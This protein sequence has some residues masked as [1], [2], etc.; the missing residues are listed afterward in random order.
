MLVHEPDG[1]TTYSLSLKISINLFAKVRASSANPLLN[2]GCPQQVCSERNSTS[3][4]SLRSTLTTHIPVSGKNWS[5][6][7]VI[8][9]ETF[10]STHAHSHQGEVEKT[11]RSFARLLE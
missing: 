2:A 11:D 8:K 7:Q 4:P 10:I 9:R 3:T 5:T 6:R 1:A